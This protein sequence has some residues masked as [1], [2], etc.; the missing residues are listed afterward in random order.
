MSLTGGRSNGGEEG[1]VSS[2]GREEKLGFG[3]FLVT[4]SVALFR[5]L[6]SWALQN[7]SQMCCCLLKVRSITISVSRGRLFSSPPSLSHPIY[8]KLL[9]FF[10][11]CSCFILYCSLHSLFL[12]SVAPSCHQSTQFLR[13]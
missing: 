10:H 2:A 11:Q 6:S 7:E 12:L 9:F 13:R 3:I 4:S 8:W 5:W 1:E